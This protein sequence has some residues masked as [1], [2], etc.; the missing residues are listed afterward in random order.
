MRPIG[1]CKLCLSE[2]L[3]HDSHILPEF[4]YKPMYKSERKFYG[5]SSEPRNNRVFQKGF[6]ERLFCTQC[7]QFLCRFEVA[8]NDFLFNGV[9]KRVRQ[10]AFTQIGELDYV[11]LKLFF[12]S[13]LWRLAISQ[14]H[15]LKGCN[16]GEFHTENLRKMIL[17]S[18]PGAWHRYPCLLTRYDFE[19]TELDD[20]IMPPKRCSHQRVWGFAASGFMFIY[21]VASHPPIKPGREYYLNEDGIAVIYHTDIRSIHVLSEHFEG[22]VDLLKTERS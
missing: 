20:M 10:G 12:M 14:T 8:G 5:V 19:G 1:V 21:R 16:L 13:L 18:N 3:I 15:F 11:R 17:A 9:G 7:E 22:V 6:R 2:A 4:M